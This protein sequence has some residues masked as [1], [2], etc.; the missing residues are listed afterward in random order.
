VRLTPARL[1]AAIVVIGLL[2]AAGLLLFLPVDPS[3][4]RVDG[5]W[6]PPAPV[7]SSGAILVLRTSRRLDLRSD[8]LEQAL[9]LAG[10]VVMRQPIDLTLDELID[11]VGNLADRAGI[12]PDAVWLLATADD[13]AAA[14]R[15]APF[16]GV[17]GL[18]LLAPEPID[19]LLPLCRDWPDGLKIGLFCAA[20]KT[21]GGGRPE[22]LFERLSGEDA[23][24][25][26]GYRSDG[27]LAATQTLSADGTVSLLRYPA[28]LPILAPIS[29]RV[30]PDLTALLH[31][32]T[33]SGDVR[34]TERVARSVAARLFRQL[35][36]GLI[37]LLALPSAHLVSL[38][39]RRI[40]S[41]R[42]QGST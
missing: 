26:P 4:D 38:A 42:S 34:S 15:A 22:Q 19:A 3:A 36:A 32:W 21:A 12:R 28:L 33:G 41:P 16:L 35:L 6:L 27:F 29:P 7:E 13:A 18:L 10:L 23:S 9:A 30:L 8:H 14:L 40:S 11:Q 2:A 17:A 1:V 31:D 5:L 37:M 39:V 24:L 25:F 20:S